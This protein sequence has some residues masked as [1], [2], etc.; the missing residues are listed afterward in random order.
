MI[1]Q[2]KHLQ[3]ALQ[4]YSKWSGK[5]DWVVMIFLAHQVCFQHLAGLDKYNFFG[6][7][8]LD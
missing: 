5:E 1:V 4:V 7:S 8:P 6:L 2:A 3:D